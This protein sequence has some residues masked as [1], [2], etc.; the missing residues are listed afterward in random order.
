[1]NGFSTLLRKE[2]LEQWRTFRLPGV[3]LVLLVFGL[4]SPILAK[5]LPEIV[6]QFA[7]QFEIN[8]PPPTSKDAIDQIIKNLGQMAPI[9]AILISMGAI[10]TEKQRGTAALVLTKPV[11]RT[12]FIAAKFAALVVTLGAGTVLGCAGGYVY[13]AILFETLPVWGFI[14]FTALMLL[15][16]LVYAAFTF[17]GSTVLRSAMLAAGLG[18]AAFVLTAGL[19]AVPAVERFMPMGLYGPVY[20]PDT[21]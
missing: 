3:C 18:L 2:V 5:Y 14:V 4:I 1:M 9:A 20:R 21:W 8:V 17:L 7:G 10:A 16:I 19:S 12:A 6:E 13:T 11:T 15:S